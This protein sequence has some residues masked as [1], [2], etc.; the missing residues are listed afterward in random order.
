MNKQEKKRLLKR[1]VATNTP[2]VLNRIDICIDI[3]GGVSEKD[4]NCIYCD[5]KYKKHIVK[6][7]SK[8]PKDKW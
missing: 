8:C 6:M 7:S 2:L 4:L 5:C 1:S 3:C